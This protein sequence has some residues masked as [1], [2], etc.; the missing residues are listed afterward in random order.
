MDQDRHSAP[1]ISNQERRL[2]E[3]TGAILGDLADEVA[4]AL[5]AALERVV[6]LAETG[7]IRTSSLV[8]LRAEIEQAQRAGTVAQRLA[9]LAV[10]KPRQRMERFDIARLLQDTLV[11][12]AERAATSGTKHL[13]TSGVSVVTADVELARNLI[14]ALVEWSMST[15]HSIVEWSVATRRTSP[16]TEI[17]CQVSGEK[18]VATK[19]TGHIPGE[20]A[21]ALHWRLV[22]HTA[23]A[24]GVTARRQATEGGFSALLE[25]PPPVGHAID[26]IT[27]DEL[28]PEEA[29]ALYSE[30]V[31]GSSL[32][33]VAG[34]RDTR[35]RVHDAVGPLQLVADFARSVE[36]AREFCAA[37]LPH[38]IVYEPTIRGQPFEPLRMELLMTS[39]NLGLVE[40]GEPGAEPPPMIGRGRPLARISRQSLTDALAPILVAEL[41]RTLRA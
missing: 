24:M 13:T 16:A 7:R 6:T 14:E 34:R 39:P 20:R 22:E 28:D 27:V 38:A 30:T 3:E 23:L 25:V 29:M 17:T 5:T 12:Q 2:R 31:A 9:Q 37:G 36:E 41:S 26:G 18:I 10:G 11:R 35:D 4:P 21:A 8:A 32:L 40:I 19:S 15:A 1:K 33:I